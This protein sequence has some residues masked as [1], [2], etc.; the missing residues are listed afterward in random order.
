MLALEMDDNIDISNF[1]VIDIFYIN[2]YL[3]ILRCIDFL[4]GISNFRY[5]SARFRYDKARIRLWIRIEIR[6]KSD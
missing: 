5:D 3:L 1:S 2:I 6:L 4:T